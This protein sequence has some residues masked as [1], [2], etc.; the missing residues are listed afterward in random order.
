MSDEL[1]RK[2][3]LQ[4]FADDPDDNGE[5]DG[6]EPDEEKDPEGS[7][8]DKKADE[9]KYSDKDV[10]DIVKKKDAI[11]KTKYEKAL[12]E[13]KDEAAKLAKMNAEQK[14]EY[15]LEKLQKENDELKAQ[16]E[17]YEL[18]KT[19]SAILKESNIDATEDILSFVVG[20]DA[21]T[22]KANIDKFVGI[23]NAQVKAAE[24]ERA[25]GKGS[26][27]NFGGGAEITDIQRRINKYRKK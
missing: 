27:K 3:D 24:V 14:R 26:P 18:S 19:A 21:E 8:D 15:E 1:K 17:R 25:T 16:A 7:D 23:I 4:L 9:K 11:W 12:K 10:D 20:S 22:T 5:P 6:K 2:Y 13:A